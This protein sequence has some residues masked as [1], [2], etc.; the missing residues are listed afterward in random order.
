MKTGILIAY[1]GR[2]EEARK[3][4][5]TLQERGRHRIASLSRSA[6]GEVQT[7]DPFHWRRIWVTV[8][9]F[10]LG[11]CIG[12]IFSATL[13]WFGAGPVSSEAVLT[14]TLACGAAGMLLAAGLFRRS[15]FG[16]E[17]KAID[18]HARW[19]VPGETVLILQG[20]VDSFRGAMAALLEKGETS[21][22]VFVFHPR[23]VAPSPPG[24][25]TTAP[26][27]PAQLQ[28]HAER[29]ATEFRVDPNRAA[30][31]DRSSGSKEAG[32]GCSRSARTSPK[33]PG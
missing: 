24:W 11:G 31:P 29:L 9:G 27:N 10:A 28:E 23:R 22:P 4:H 18:D 15:R 20:S 12:A 5:G 6:E 3:A 21:P 17:R 33:Q 16:V 13:Q 25:R 1:F 26:L 30:I 32:G 7:W 14:W 2:Q 8:A 19:L